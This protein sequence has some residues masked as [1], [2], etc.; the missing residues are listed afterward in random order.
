MMKKISVLLF[1]LLAAGQVFAANT[2][3]CSGT[4]GNGT[5]ISGNAANFVRIDILPK[6]SANVFLNWDQTANGFAVAAA[7]SKGKQMFTGNTGGG[8][9]GSAGVCAASTCTAAQLATPLATALAAA[10]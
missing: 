1:G 6:C 7:S 10:T 3:A 9:V 8:A 5:V 2:V 4:G